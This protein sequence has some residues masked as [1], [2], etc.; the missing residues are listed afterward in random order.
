MGLITAAVN[1]GGPREVMPEFQ[2]KLTPQYDRVRSLRW[3]P[4]CKNKK[5]Q[6][7]LVCWGCNLRLK[8]A[9]NGTY[10]PLEWLIPKLDEYLFD[11]N[12]TQAL[13][14]LGEA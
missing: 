7:L 1:G 13:S 8:R 14:W 2:S 12:E 9:Y 10:G 4:K 3:C 11:H 6:G 5:D